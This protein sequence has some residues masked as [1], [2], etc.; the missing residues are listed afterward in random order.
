[1]S[2]REKLLTKNILCAVMAAG[3]VSFSGTVF[4]ADNVE[5]G[6]VHVDENG[7]IIGNIQQD[8]ITEIT[9]GTIT[10]TDEEAQ[11]YDDGGISAI[12]VKGEGKSFTVNDVNIT[13]GV[14]VRNG[15]SLTINDSTAIAGAYYVD[16]V[17]NSGTDFKTEG[18]NLTVNNSVVKSEIYAGES[19]DDKHTTGVITFNNS[20]IDTNT[21]YEPGDIIA[22]YNSRIILNGNEN[23][24]YKVGRFL[25]ALNDEKYQNPG[26]IEINGGTLIA[27]NLRSLVDGSLLKP[28]PVDEFTQAD[29]DE[30]KD[31]TVK[32]GIV[33]KDNGV[34]QT[35][36][37]QIFEY[38]I[39]TTSD[40][41][42]LAST[43][44]G[45][46]TN[47][48]ISYEGGTINFTD[49]RYTLAY[50]D[51]AKENMA[52]V[53][54]ANI[55]MLGKLVNED[56]ENINLSVEEAVEHV[57]ETG[58]T[59]TVE[60]DKD[61]TKLVVGNGKT[62]DSVQ[63]S[64]GSFAAGKLLLGENTS[65]IE[66]TDGKSLGLNGTDDGDL[67]T[68]NK[69]DLDIIVNDTDSKLT[70]GKKDMNS[71]TNSLTA[72][73]T[74]NSGTLEAVSGNTEVDGNITLNSGN[75]NVN[76]DATLTVNK[77][78]TAQQDVN[79][80]IGDKDSAGIL[81]AQD[82]QLNGATVY[83][84]PVWKDGRTI[85][86]ASKAGIV[87]AEETGV[88]G[89][90]IVGENSVLT[91]GST[92]TNLAE[93]AFNKTE[94]I[95]GDGEDKVLSAV[96]VAS[97]QDISNGSLLVDKTAAGTEVLQNGEVNFG[98]NSILIVD[99]KNLN[100]DEAAIEGVT[101]AQIAQNEADKQNGAKLYID[102]AEA[103]KKYTILD[104]TNGTE[105]WN[106]DNVTSNNTLM[107]F[108]KEQSEEDQTNYYTVTDYKNVEDELGDGV[109]AANVINDTLQSDIKSGNIDNA[110]FK[111]FNKAVD[112]NNNRTDKAQIT[113]LNSVANMG[114]LAGVNHGAYSMSNTMTD[115]VAD[116]LSLANHG[117]QD[118]DIWARYIHSEEDIEDMELGGINAD[119]DAT[120]NGIIVGGDFYKNGK[121]T[122]GLAV[123]YADG[124]IDGSNMAA[125][126]E[127][128][129]EYYG[130]SLYGRIDNGDS[131]LLGDISF[132]HSSNDITQYNSDEKI[133]ASPDAD[134]FSIGLR[135]EKEIKAGN[136][137]LVPYAGVRYMHMGA[138][139]YTNSLGM[140]YDAD[141][142]NLF[143][144][145]VGLK[146]TAEIKHNDWT[147]KPMAEVGY[148]WNFGDKNTDQTISLNGASNTFGFD[149]VDDGVFVGRLGIEAENDKMA[150][151]IGYEYQDG[152]SSSS[153][154]WM[155][156]V[157]FKF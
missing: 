32:G 16:G 44:S 39:D 123:A 52:L 89:S 6:I 109:V 8:D 21:Q 34:I 35:K 130:A 68:G 31:H 58:T 46:V 125:R 7:T 112:T 56:G 29:I 87:F 33:L 19:D 70:L 5:H 84:D 154:K 60:A 50:L 12:Q 96:Y 18:G 63:Y 2:E 57:G 3:V 140:K 138:G 156:N 49:E 142:Q 20:N 126:T 113:A 145:P 139:D 132:L 104:L 90:L 119:Y 157:T 86:E 150:Y 54:E 115:A 101:S 28:D 117:E 105:Q 133:T 136:G 146:Y 92:D 40:E 38:G 95:W 107:I 42:A 153:D 116:H 64:N 67:I 149:T 11:K 41:T 137:K 111:F 93:E 17:I 106:A 88:D 151:G 100:E 9:G 127:N 43:D 53:G 78:L 25:A 27:D 134:A 14:S 143:L 48:Y 4:A 15:A 135:A 45:K 62:D 80:N 26:R 152:D 65:A 77:T 94:Q 120:Y 1:M 47:D 121:G 122:V 10:V 37:G 85:G 30:L 79:I 98:K 36:T 118:N 66:I 99:G 108:G 129:A 51:S 97:P 128:D 155:A 69:G 73:V 144:L 81:K 147:I 76:G 148:V 72:N 114:E 22:D 103:G 75:F 55:N 61:I 131:A 24:T 110:A 13:G 102:N 59:V 91:L 23:N 124:D 82:T 74:V 71:L 83:L 141:E